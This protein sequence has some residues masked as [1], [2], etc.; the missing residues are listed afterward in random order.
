[1]L[2]ELPP[3]HD[4]SHLRAALPYVRNWH[5]AVDCGAHQ[6]IWTRELRKHFASVESFEPV[7]SNF[8]HLPE[9]DKADSHRVYPY[10]IGDKREQVRFAAGTENTGQWHIEEGGEVEADLYP[11][12]FFQFDQ[13]G[14]LKFDVEGYELPALK[15][16]AET[17]EAWKPVVIIEVNGLHQRYGV[18]DGAAELWLMHRGYKLREHIGRDLIWSV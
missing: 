14:L 8:W 12:D 4:L 10:G 7:P 5:R 6:G 11:L 15:G 13:V 18:K 2:A 1:M 16:A 9:L 3:D 17:I